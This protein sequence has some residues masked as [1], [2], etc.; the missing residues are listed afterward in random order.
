MV[1]EALADI[2]ELVLESGEEELEERV[3][4]E[5]S[6]DTDGVM[7]VTE[8]AD[9][10]EDVVEACNMLVLVAGVSSVELADCV[11]FVEDMLDV[12]ADTVDDSSSVS[13]EVVRELD[14][15][16]LI[17]LDSD[18]SAVDVSSLDVEGVA[19]ADVSV[20]R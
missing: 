17:E 9:W 15:V 20:S 13:N 12:D 6:A 16:E 1:G 11:D 19:Y 3:L 10:T 14:A 7:P 2:V 8:P 4:V 5:L 18:V